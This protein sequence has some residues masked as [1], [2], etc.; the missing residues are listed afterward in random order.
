M[1]WDLKNHQP[2][3]KADLGSEDRLT[4]LSTYNA[5]GTECFSLDSQGPHKHPR[6]LPPEA[7]RTG[8]PTLQL[9]NQQH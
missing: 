8:V 1:L 6:P 2:T 4:F 9:R 5:L 3:W 7:N